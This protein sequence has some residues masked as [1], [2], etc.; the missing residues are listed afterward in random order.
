MSIKTTVDAETESRIIKEHY[1]KIGKKG[2]SAKSEKKTL[3][4]RENAR[5]P[6]KKKE[7]PLNEQP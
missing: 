5:K 4:S 2:G 1:K 6:R 7:R 3:S